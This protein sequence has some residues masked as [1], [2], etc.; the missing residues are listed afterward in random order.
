MTSPPR[1][2]YRRRLPHWHPAGQTFFITFRLTNSL[3]IAVI[4][5]LQEERER[6][7]KKIRVQFSGPE[8]YEELYKLDKKYFG[9]YDAWLDRC[10][11]ESPR[12]L[13]QENIARIVAEQIHALNGERYRLIAYCLMP[14]HG[15]LMIDTADYFASNPMPHAGRTAPYPLADALKLLKGRTSRYCNQALHREGAFWHHESYDH[16]VRNEKEYQRIIWYIVNNP[17]KAG[18]VE[19]WEA[20]P[21]TYYAE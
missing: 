3:P 11:A 9:R 7:R 15:H 10:V 13:V 2:F 14:N 4:Q 21:F 8:Q 5:Q 16:V 12:W 18:L 1:D 17:V 6:E 20:W 19:N